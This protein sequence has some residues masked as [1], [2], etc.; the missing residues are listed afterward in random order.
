MGERKK[1]NSKNCGIKWQ[2]QQAA[3]VTKVES[4]Q[5]ETERQGGDVHGRGRGWVSNNFTV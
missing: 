5:T 2:W 4:K 1:W 3:V